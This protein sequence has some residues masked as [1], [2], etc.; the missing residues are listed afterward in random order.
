VHSDEEIAEAYFRRRHE[1]FWAWEEVQERLRMPEEGWRIIRL[2]IEKAPSL[3]AL[4]YVGAGPVEDLLPYSLEFMDM[5][6]AAAREDERLQFAL[7]N[8]CLDEFQEGD[9]SVWKRWMAMKNEFDLDA[10]R[11]IIY[12][13]SAI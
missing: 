7:S 12:P 11:A 8:A 4:G 2:L 5:V 13:E 6:A 10:K 3:E 9:Q 1:D